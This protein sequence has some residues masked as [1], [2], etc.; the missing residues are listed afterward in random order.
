MTY[1]HTSESFK[2]FFDKGHGFRYVTNAVMNARE[3]SAQAEDAREKAVRR[4]IAD[5]E[6]IEMADD[7]AP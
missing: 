6:C 2:L 4:L 7:S 1:E 5:I 3:E